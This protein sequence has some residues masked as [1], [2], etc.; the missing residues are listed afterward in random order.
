M[1]DRTPDEV[2]WDELVSWIVQ[3]RVPSKAGGV[4]VVDDWQHPF[5]ARLAPALRTLFAEG[6]F[7]ETART[8]HILVSRQ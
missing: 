8:L 7:A 4:L 1:S 5:M 2:V 6:I 3:R